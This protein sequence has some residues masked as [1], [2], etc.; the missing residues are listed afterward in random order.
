MA[1]E[2]AVTIVRDLHA[3]A[4]RCRL[5]PRPDGEHTQTHTFVIA[6]KHMNSHS[7]VVPTVMARWRLR[8]HGQVGTPR[9]MT[10]NRQ[11]HA[12]RGRITNG[13]TY[14]GS[15]TGALREGKG[16]RG[17]HEGRNLARVD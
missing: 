13:D 5:A 2:T 16:R 15:C 14:T 1:S 9:G 7:I 11:Q 6:G 4:A 10:S 8:T 17:G 12:E 3:H